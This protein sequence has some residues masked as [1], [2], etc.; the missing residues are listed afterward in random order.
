M[1]WGEDVKKEDKMMRGWDDER[2]W[3]RDWKDESRNEWMEVR[4]RFKLNLTNIND[5]N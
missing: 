3:I 2:M 1:R 4:M 5:V